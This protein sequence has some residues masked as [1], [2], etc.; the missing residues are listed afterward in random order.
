M[1]VWVLYE[2][3]QQAHE[4]FEFLAVAPANHF[5]KMPQEP[6][7]LRRPLLW[8][9]TKPAPKV[10]LVGLCRA[11]RLEHERFLLAVLA[12]LPTFLN[13]H[14]FA[15]SLLHKNVLNFELELFVGHVRKG[16]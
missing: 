10:V 7:L 12:L 1:L 8:F 16:S 11:A 6:P 13:R 15:V 9:D 4:V 2:P 3:S 5:V 14:F